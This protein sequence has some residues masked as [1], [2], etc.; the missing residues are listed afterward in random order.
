MSFCIVAVAKNNAIGKD[1]KLL[2]HISDD[3]KRFKKLTTG[4]TIVMGKNTYFSL[5]FRPLPKRTN[6]VI[7]DIPGEIIEGCVMAY[8]IEEAINKCDDVNENFIIGGASI[9]RQFLPVA[10]KLYLTKVDKDFEADC[11]FPEINPEEWE[12]ISSE[13]GTADDSIDFSF[14]YLIYKR[15]EKVK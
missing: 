10:D 11:F 1:N 4:N 6:V 12:L 2:W 7:T 8:T 9:Y 15:I 5:P 3:L 13:S 14:S